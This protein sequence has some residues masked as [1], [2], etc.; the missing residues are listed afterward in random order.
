M[1]QPPGTHATLAKRARH[2]LVQYAAVFAYLYV[3]FAALLFYKASILRGQGISYTPYGLA[4]VKALILAKF[5]LLG[6]ALKIG[7]PSTRGRLMFAILHKSLLFLP[8]LIVLSVVEEATVALLHG[9]SAREAVAALAGG[10]LPEAFATSLLMLLILLPYFAFRE[11]S[12]SLGEGK[13][14][15]LLTDRRLPDA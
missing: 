10:T 9:H 14:L 4:V 12:F 5:I 8:L 15:K 11:I 3:C 2:E 13:L 7:G 1:E 6:H